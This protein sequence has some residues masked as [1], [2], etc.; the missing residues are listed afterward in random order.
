MAALIHVLLTLFGLLL[1]C[2]ASRT[3]VKTYI[4]VGNEKQIMTSPNYPKPYGNVLT[5][6]WYLTANASIPYGV[7]NFKVIDCRIR[8][9][10]PCYEE[11]IIIYNGPNEWYPELD[12]WCG[13]M[14]PRGILTGTRRSSHVV[15]TASARHHSNPGFRIEFWAKSKPPRSIK[16]AVLTWA[17]YT[18]FGIFVGVVILL[19][20]YILVNIYARKY[21]N[22][23]NFKPKFLFT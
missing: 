12:S 9:A 14:F 19:V 2:D 22:V 8:D 18:L 15:F 10:T 11:A 5:Y 16:R 7:V 20:G 4:T 21:R 3:T 17:H 23:Q 6:E 13:Y 1:S